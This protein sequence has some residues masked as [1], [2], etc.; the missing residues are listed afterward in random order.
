MIPS[1]IYFKN[2]VF[3]SIKI[4]NVDG[5]LKFIGCGYSGKEIEFDNIETKF[6]PFLSLISIF[7]KKDIDD[8]K[9][10][11]WIQKYGFFDSSFRKIPE[12]SESDYDSFINEAKTITALWTKFNKISNREIE[13]FKKWL[14]AH[15]DFSDIENAENVITSIYPFE[16]IKDGVYTSG[17]N[18]VS[19]N[20]PMKDLTYREYQYA[21]FRYILGEI[22]SRIKKVSFDINKIR[23]IDK[24]DNSKSFYSIEN[25]IMTPPDLLTALYLYFFQILHSNVRICP[26][27][28]TPFYNRRSDAVACSPKHSNTCKRRKQRKTKPV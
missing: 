23:I 20:I 21:G 6:N 10:C 28:S 3:K 1:H 11:E 9:I 24:P 2:V 19:F 18:T 4:A 27:C 12:R 22:T 16:D 5:R 7:M 13:K 15:E 25:S 8:N 26:I 14:E 17:K